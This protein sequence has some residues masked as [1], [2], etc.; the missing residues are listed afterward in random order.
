VKHV[1]ILANGL[2]F[3]AIE[4]GQ[5]P[6]VLLLHGFPDTPATW[7]AIRPVLSANG[8]R[9][10]SPFTR[11]YAPTEIPVR[12]AYDSDTLGRDVLAL[13]GA[14][15]ES[16]AIV[17]GHDWGADAAYAAAILE[18][19]KIRLLV[20]LAIPHPASLRPT[21]RMLWAGRHFF[22]L[23][24]KNAA[25]MVRRNDFAHVDELVRRWSPKW[26]FGPEE[27]AAVKDVFRQPGSLEAALGYYRALRP[28]KKRQVHVPTVGFAGEDDV[29]DAAEF[30]RAGRFFTAGYRVVSM[31]GGHFMHRE[32]PK[33]FETELLAALAPYRG[34]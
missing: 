33:R 34:A 13:I 30:E 15:G 8:W 25:E 27:T 3:A 20:T 21:P 24:L 29:L 23:R 4:E 16:Q 12:G 1:T 5:G 6:L 9:T 19:S 14:L 22:S 2:K 17:V 7:D 28:A 31:P 11:G 32:H 10:V 18:P 26:K